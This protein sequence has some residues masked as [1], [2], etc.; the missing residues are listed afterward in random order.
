MKA[1][2]INEQLKYVQ[3]ANSV[4]HFMKQSRFLKDA[5]E[6]KGLSPRYCEE[7]ISYLNVQIDG[8]LI[9]KILVLQKCFCDVPLHKLTDNFQ[10]SLEKEEIQSLNDDE[11][12]EIVNNNTHPDYYGKYAIAFSKMWCI[13]QNLQPVHYVNSEAE[14][15]R[16]LKK[17]LEYAI[18]QEDLEDVFFDDV[19]NRLCYLKPLCGEMVRTLKSGKTVHISKNFHDEKEWRYVPKLED[20]EKVKKGR[21]I[22]KLPIVEKKETVSNELEKE[23]YKDIWLRFEYDDVKYIVVPNDAERISLIKFIN[24]IPDD[25]F[26]SDVDVDI[27]RSVLISKILVL[28]EI[29]EDW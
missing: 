3:S 15:A 29:K 23:N 8:V 24:D 20:L 4:F 27:Q 16:D 6:R 28:N 14:F 22:V 18:S 11:R 10:I 25:N 12:E 9:E 7:D 19:I 21:V 1:E 26:K 5:L 13:D 17:V 2:L